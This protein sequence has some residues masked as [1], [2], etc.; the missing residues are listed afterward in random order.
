MS[1]HQREDSKTNKTVDKS[2]VCMS[3][4]GPGCLGTRASPLLFER[5]RTEEAFLFGNI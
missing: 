2:S 1:T 3:P 4:A 5:V